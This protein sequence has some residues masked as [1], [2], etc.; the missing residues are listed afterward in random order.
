MNSM[1]SSVQLRMLLFLTFV[2]AIGCGS[3]ENRKETGTVSGTVMYNGEPL[4]IGSLLFI[5][6]G[7]GPTAEANIDSNGKYWMGTYE[8]AD[9]AVLGKHKVM[10]TAITAPGGSGLPEDVIDGDGAPVSVIPEFYGDQEKSG[11]EVEVKAGENNVD[12]ILTAKAGE[13]KV[14]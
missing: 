10:I 9:G 4:K 12:F 6:V 8:L 1:F 11:L 14:N 3:G 13:V 2:A 7:G 5:P